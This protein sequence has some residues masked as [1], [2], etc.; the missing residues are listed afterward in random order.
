MVCGI[1]VWLGAFAPVLLT[2][3][4]ELASPLGA[5]DRSRKR[6]EPFARGRA[7][8]P[9]PLAVRFS[10]RRKLPPTQE[11][12]ALPHTHDE[13]VT[14]RPGLYQRSFFRPDLHRGPNVSTP[15]L[16]SRLLKVSTTMLID[17]GV[18]HVSALPEPSI[19]ISNYCT[20]LPSVRIILHTRFH[21]TDSRINSCTVSQADLR[22]LR[23]RTT[24]CA[25][26]Y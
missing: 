23:L 14:S 7:P 18:R 22:H 24:T 25:I 15:L 11:L 17:L 6:A 5:V 8:R 16:G 2:V 21:S 9:P 1:V 13:L 19:F 4:S 12:Q 20:Y 10:R 26:F 3:R